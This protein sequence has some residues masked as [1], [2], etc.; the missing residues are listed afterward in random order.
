[1]ANILQFMF[2]EALCKKA[3]PDVPLHQCDIYG[4]KEA[5]K[6]LRSILENGASVPWQDQ[7]FDL[8][9][10]SD[11]TADSILSYFEPLSQYLDSELARMGE[12]PGWL[13]ADAAIDQYMSPTCVDN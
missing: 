5:G 10:Y 6:L 12:T 3:Q 13:D 1:M 2:H 9:G 11:L 4:S 8:T 7:L